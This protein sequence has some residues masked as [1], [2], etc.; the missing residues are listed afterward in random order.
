MELKNAQVDT[1][2]N[3]VA[4]GAATATLTSGNFGTPV[5]AIYLVF[6]YDVSAKFEVKRCTVAGASITGMSHVS[7]ANVAHSAGCKV[8]RMMV[9]EVIDDIGT[10]IDNVED[11]S[12]I[13]TGAIANRQLALGVCVQEV[14]ASF[15]AYAGGTTTIPMDDTIPQNTEGI[16]FMTLAITPK[17]A[18]NKLVIE[19]EAYVSS[20]VAANRVVGALFQDSVA[21]ALKVSEV[22]VPAATASVM[23]TLRHE[24]VAG[25]TSAITFKFRAG[26]TSG[27]TGFNG[28][29]GV[30]VFGAAPKSS[31]IIREYKA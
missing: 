31:I 19:I 3:D 24:M 25:T 7:G 10:R 14:D 21:S 15:S 29:G 22:N 8:G 16:E 18:T 9:A 26:S 30:R 12:A 1:L 23:L 28:Y 6:D 20:S 17:S 5:G 2:L 27:T 4:Q 11:G 13:A